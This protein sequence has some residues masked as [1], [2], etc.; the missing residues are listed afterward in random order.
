MADARLTG[1]LPWIA[2][3]L[4]GCSAGIAEPPAAAN[5]RAASDTARRTPRG[6]ERR[7]AAPGAGFT[8]GFR[9]IEAVGQG[10]EFPLPD[11]RG[12]RR[13]TREKQSWV[14]RH[15]ASASVLVVRAWQQ[16]SIAR[17][18]DC[19][20][21]ARLWRPELPVVDAAEIVDAHEQRLAGTYEGQVTL[22]LQPGMSPEGAALFGHALA[23]GS[24][25]RSC[26]MIAFSTS[27]SGPMATNTVAERLGAVTQAVFGRARRLDIGERVIVPRM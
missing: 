1:L 15:R 26:L 9:I 8:E 6:T 7:P 24:D 5:A 12:W 10:L 19:E 21:Q 16:D 18:D 4:L 11:A 17:I 22:W 2:A 14:A 3:C 27:A 20:R 13:D 23:F 25:A